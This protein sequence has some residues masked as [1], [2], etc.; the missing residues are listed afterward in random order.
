ML[1]SDDSVA[2]FKVIPNVFSNEASIPASDGTNVLEFPARWSTQMLHNL[3]IIIQDNVLAAAISI[4]TATYH[5]GPIS[6]TRG[7]WDHT[8]IFIV[9]KLLSL[10]M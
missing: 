7:V 1:T 4:S 5:R 6:Y 3:R 2:S 8:H 10:I 9:Q